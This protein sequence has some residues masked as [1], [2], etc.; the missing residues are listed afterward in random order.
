[1]KFHEV[2]ELKINRNKSHAL[3]CS[4]RTKPTWL[5]AFTWSWVGEGDL[6]KLLR[7]P[8][9]LDIFGDDVNIFLL[10]KIENKLA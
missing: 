10:Q 9:G 1:M 3:W 4:P 7:T 2:L 5:E 8:F 6:I